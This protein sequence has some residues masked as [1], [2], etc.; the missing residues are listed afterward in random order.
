MRIAADQAG[1]DPKI[2]A[3]LKRNEDGLVA[4]IADVFRDDGEKPLLNRRR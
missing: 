3:R 1:L 2:A 4:A